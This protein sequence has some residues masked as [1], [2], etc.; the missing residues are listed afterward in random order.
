MP[1]W[2]IVTRA[3]TPLDRHRAHRRSLRFLSEKGARLHAVRAI[4]GFGRAKGE[5]GGYD[6][7]TPR[8]ATERTGA[9]RG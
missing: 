7:M 6:M 5:A 3:E 9:A 1:R 8:D 4:Y 2:P